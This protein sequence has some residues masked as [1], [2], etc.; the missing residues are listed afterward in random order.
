MHSTR[1]LFASLLL[2]ASTLTGCSGANP[3]PLAAEAPRAWARPLR[4][5]TF[6]KTDARRER[7]RYLA[8]TIVQCMMCHSERDW[9]QPGAPPRADRYFAGS[10]MRDDSTTRLVAANLTPDRETGIGRWSDDM[11]VRAIREGVGHDGRALHPQMWY[12]SFRDLSDEDVASIVVFLRSLPP[13]KNTLPPTRLTE[14]RKREIE[15][16]LEPLTTP[17]HE[18]DRTDPLA[19]GRHLIRV[20]DCEGCHTSWYSKRN[21]GLLAG[22]NWIELAAQAAF[23]TN[24]TPDSNAI[25][26]WD[27]ATFASMM[28]T[29]K[30]GTMHGVMPWVAFGGLTDEDLSAIRAVLMDMPAVEHRIDNLS[31][32]TP[33]AVCGQSHGLGETNTLKRPTGIA[34]PSALLASYQGTYR[35]SVPPL[36]WMVTLEKGRLIAREQDGP[37]AVLIPMTRTRFHADGWLAPV[38]FRGDSA[39]RPT[40][41]VSLEVEPLVGVRAR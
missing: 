28:R 8:T 14:E 4:D 20:A 27:E 3:E 36:V 22:G 40:Q 38:E 24:I 39:G 19:L 30:G 5:T 34:L 11:L 26:T 35:T 29:G 21:P 10:V 9:S 25:G 2:A 12:G 13:I 6:A 33:C 1:L 7:G 41:L 18:R 23:S 16:S 32:A 31:P 17:V 37:D 15:A